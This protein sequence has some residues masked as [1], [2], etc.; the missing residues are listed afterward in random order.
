[1]TTKTSNALLAAWFVVIGGLLAAVV[2][3]S[4]KGCSPTETPPDEAVTPVQPKPVVKAK[5]REHHGDSPRRGTAGD[6]PSTAKR[7]VIEGVVLVPGGEPA[8]GAHVALFEPTRPGKPSGP[9]DKEELRLLSSMIY[10]PTEEY[11]TPRPLSKWTGEFDRAQTAEAELAGADTKPDGTFSITLPS[12]YGAGPYRLTAAKEGVGS[13]AMNEVTA[14]DD[15]VQLVLGPAASV[16]GVVLTEVDSAPVEHA[17]VIF[18]NGARRFPAETDSAGK[19]SADGVTPGFYQVTVAAK[20]RTPLFDNRFKVD[21]ASI[22]PITLRMPRGTKLVVKAV[23]EQLDAPAPRKGEIPGDPVPAAKIVAYN[24]DTATYVFGV[25]NQEGV[26]EFPAMPGG[27]YVLNGLAKGFISMGE[28]ACVVDKNQLTQEETV[29]F[30][31]AVE[32]PIEVVDEDGRALAGVEFFTVNNDDKFDQVRSI[33]VGATDSD[34]K[35]K[36]PF[37]FDGNRSKLFGFKTGYAVV[38]AHPDDHETGE[39]LKLVAKKAVHVHG[40]V[41]SSDGRPVPDAL[42]MIDVASTDPNATA[43]EDYSLEIRADSAGRYDFGFLP[44]VEGITLSASG[45]DGIS[46]EDKELELASGKDDYELDLVLD[47]DGDAE[48]AVVPTRV[49][50]ADDVKKADESKK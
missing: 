6:R 20:G 13:A 24:E 12:R 42:V 49:K 10:I 44:R 22:T 21:A 37:E 15:K 50:K 31:K 7:F 38:A 5:P 19:F 46:Q 45:P 32:T 28:S 3:F 17:H 39:P 26:V 25:T 36:F 34:G 23:V 41:K 1:M 18:D 2:F 9:P 47:L 40:A 33:K 16:K 35:M 14:G 11:D 27:R 8:P 48:P 29:A 4:L 43:T 30:E